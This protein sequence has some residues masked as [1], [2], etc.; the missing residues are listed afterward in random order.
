MNFQVM[1]VYLRSG[2]AL[3]RLV[4]S[5]VVSSWARHSVRLNMFPKPVGGTGNT[6][7]GDA[8]LEVCHIVINYLTL[9]IVNISD[10]YLKIIDPM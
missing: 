8:T 2:S 5:L 10:T 6:S 1:I 7:N 9:N 4:A 3:Q